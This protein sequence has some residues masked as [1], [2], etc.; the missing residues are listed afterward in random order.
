MYVG[1][2]VKYLLCLSDFNGTW[3]F[4]T[5]FRKILRHRIYEKF[6]NRGPSYSM[7]ANRRTDTHDEII[8]VFFAIS[9]NSPNRTL[10]QNTIERNT[11]MLWPLQTGN[12]E[13]VSN[14]TETKLSVLYSNIRIG[15]SRQ[16]IKCEARWNMFLRNGFTEHY[17]APDHYHSRLR[18][19]DLP[20]WRVLSQ[21]HGVNHRSFETSSTPLW[22]PTF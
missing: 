20:K 10:T 12:T 6:V 16:P 2:H 7:R 5:Y 4:S 9:A 18:H 21:K 19:S 8:V 14:A 11:V 1:L 13:S 15:G 22:E 3:I 17:R